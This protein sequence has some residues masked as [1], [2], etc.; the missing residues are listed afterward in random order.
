MWFKSPS[1]HRSIMLRPVRTSL[2]GLGTSCV[3][4]GDPGGGAGECYELH[5]SGHRLAAGWLAESHGLHTSRHDG[6]GSKHCHDTGTG[7]RRRH[8]A[9]HPTGPDPR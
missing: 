4:S 1:G 8:L 5:P 7:A 2:Q 3:C 6:P 9:E